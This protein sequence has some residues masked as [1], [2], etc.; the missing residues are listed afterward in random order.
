MMFGYNADK[1]RNDFP[2]LSKP[3]IYLDNACMSLKPKQVI[4]KIM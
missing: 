4:E 1:I 3:L 2:M